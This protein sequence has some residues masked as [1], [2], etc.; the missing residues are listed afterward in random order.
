MVATPIQLVVEQS[1]DDPLFP[2]EDINYSPLAVGVVGQR[3]RRAKVELFAGKSFV[4]PLGV[5]TR[6]PREVI[7]GPRIMR[8]TQRLAPRK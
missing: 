3:N 5:P 6:L 8:M 4:K 7:E 1:I 2:R